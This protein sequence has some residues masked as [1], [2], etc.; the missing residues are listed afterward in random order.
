MIIA[1]IFSSCYHNHQ[2]SLEATYP[3]FSWV[4]AES[5]CHGH[6]FKV[7]SA[8]WWLRM[9]DHGY[10]M[11]GS[12]RIINYL[13][14]I[15]EY[16][17]YV[18]LLSVMVYITSLM[19]KSIATGFFLTTPAPPG[20]AL[21]PSD[22]HLGTLQWRLQASPGIPNGCPSEAPGFPQQVSAMASTVTGPTIPSPSSGCRHPREA[23]NVPRPCGPPQWQALRPGG[24]ANWSDEHPN[25]WTALFILGM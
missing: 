4:L 11:G 24:G 13:G 10:Y 14:W 20:S 6:R 19:G 2:L 16:H 8:K 9:V 17:S 15:G 7:G 1:S 12:P 23:D 5:P 3:W 18:F 21:C 25:S 22:I